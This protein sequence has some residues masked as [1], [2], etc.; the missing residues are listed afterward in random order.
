MEQLKQPNLSV[1]GE[2]GYCLA[3]V[4]EVFGIAP[5]YPTALAAWDAST[6]LNHPSVTPPIN[7]SV[8]V[9][10]NYDGPDGH[11]A[12]WH[13]GTIYSTSAQGDK[14]FPSISA[15]TSWMGEGFVYLGWS[16]EVNGVRVVE[17]APAPAPT[18]SGSTLNLSVDNTP[19]HLYKPGGPYNPTVKADVLGM[20][21]PAE[22]GGLSYP[23]IASLG[24]G[25]YRIKSEDYGVGDLWTAG[26]NVTVT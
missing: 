7:V 17:A 9:Y 19:F 24:N 5:K 15:L 23:I 14:T 1:V 21:N 10:F 6:A 3:Y 16:E 18:P 13:E 11:V 25:I 26:S 12:V 22:F 8:P 2:D 20:I 4:T